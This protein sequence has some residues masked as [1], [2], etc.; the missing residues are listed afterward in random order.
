MQNGA[1]KLRRLLQKIQYT[2]MPKKK[3]TCYLVVDE[4]MYNHGAFKHDENGYKQAVKFKTKKEKTE[5]KTF[6][7]IEK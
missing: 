4:K 6:K 1:K 2:I 7:I 5:R 3:K